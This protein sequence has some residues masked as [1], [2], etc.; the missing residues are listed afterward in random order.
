MTGFTTTEGEIPFPVKAPL[1][2]S[3]AGTLPCVFVMI[4]FKNGNEKSTNNER[5]HLL[6]PQP[7]IF[8][9]VWRVWTWGRSQACLW[10]RQLNTNQKKRFLKWVKLTPL[11]EGEAT[12]RMKTVPG[13]QI[14][15]IWLP[16]LYEEWIGV[17]PSLKTHVPDT[18]YTLKLEGQDGGVITSQIH[19]L[20][21]GKFSISR[22]SLSGRGGGGGA[23]LSSKHRIYN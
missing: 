23:L 21:G 22:S 9:T 20:N 5:C 18:K 6:Q 2:L 7:C 3:D 16:V 15:V 8:S 10:K 12:V 11:Y 13:I 4:K 14:I 17:C 19:G 1:F